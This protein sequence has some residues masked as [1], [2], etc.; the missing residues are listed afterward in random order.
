M[1]GGFDGTILMVKVDSKGV[2]S[3]AIHASATAAAAKAPVTGGKPA[4]AAKVFS[5]DT[6][7]GGIVAGLSDKS[8]SIFDSKLAIVKSLKFAFKVT[9]VHVRGR[10][11]LVGT[12]GGQ[13]FEIP[14][15]LDAGV[16]GG[17]VEGRFE[18]LT[19]GH[20]E[21]ELWALALSRSSKG[22]AGEAGAARLS[23]AWTAGEDN[24]L[25]LW[26]L[27][28]H[29]LERRGVLNPE[30]GPA[31]PLVTKAS[32]TS[33]FPQ[34]QCARAL[35]LSP[36]EAHLAAGTNDGALTV[37]DAH[38]L[39][40]IVRVDLNHTGQRHVVGQEGNW[41][42]TMA[43]SPNGHLLAVGT[44]G[45]AIVILDVQHKYKVLSTITSHHSFLTHMDWSS[46]GDFLRSNDGAYE[47]LFHSLAVPSAPKQ[48]VSAQHLRD[49]VW[50]SHTCVF[51]W[52]NVGVIK[53]GD[54]TFVNSVDA[55]MVGGPAK[56]KPLIVT[57]D[58]EGK[59]G[60]YRWPANAP[61]N[62]HFNY[63]GHSSHV[64]SVR[65]TADGQHVLSTGGHDKSLFVWRVG[66]YVPSSSG[67]THTV[68]K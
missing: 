17:P 7:A 61:T 46:N 66:P 53:E 16:E 25:L 5:L 55:T 2:A 28:S 41:I 32:T 23:R 65:F 59:V 3:K 58:D 45:S 20:M 51:C 29:R 37:F 48:V 4:P 31:G 44:H 33:T 14:G 57:A 67:R 8:V 30:K 10:D 39:E 52:T 47:L 15:A 24:Q 49:E 38:S 68:A 62:T 13:V 54:G 1:L 21:G 35:A 26:D 27:R 43:Y 36:D 11:L 6:Y 64:T 63:N 9:A 12:Q 18:P 34:N 56:D 19:H 60:L 22:G 40:P 42:Q 50:A